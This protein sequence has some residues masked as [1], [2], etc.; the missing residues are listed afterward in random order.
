[1]FIYHLMNTIRMKHFVC[2]KP[3]KKLRVPRF[4]LQ[5]FGKIFWIIMMQFR[6]T[7]VW[8][9]LRWKIGTPS[10]VICMS[11][12]L[13]VCSNLKN[14]F[15]G[16]LVHNNLSSWAALTFWVW[17]CMHNYKN[18]NVFNM[19]P[20]IVIWSFKISVHSEICYR[21][22][23]LK[24]L[25]TSRFQPNHYRT[26]M[27]ITWVAYIFH[28]SF[29]RWSFLS[30]IRLIPSVYLERFRDIYAKYIWNYSWN[31]LI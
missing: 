21:D 29:V 18:E 24:P 20:L 26:G 11:K 7:C 22:V 10:R 13:C 14:I 27:P 6:Y 17:L 25:L 16:S 8:V 3:H 5:L 23:I 31:Q 1:M 15:I 2:L 28:F 9:T 30:E 4:L 19:L 12:I